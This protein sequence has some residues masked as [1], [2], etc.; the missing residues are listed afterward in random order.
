MTTTSN[1]TARR[2]RQ[3]RKPAPAVPPPRT[4]SQPEIE[5]VRER[6]ALMLCG[7]I[8]PMARIINERY[9]LLEAEWKA[10]LVEAEA[11]YQSETGERMPRTSEEMVV[12]ARLAG[13]T[14]AEAEGGEYNLDQIHRQLIAGKRLDQRQATALV[15][16]VRVADSAALVDKYQRAA[17]A[18]S[19]NGKKIIAFLMAND[20]HRESDAAPRRLIVD[21]KNLRLSEPQV[22]AAIEH[23][24]PRVAAQ[25]GAAIICGKPSRGTWLTPEG[26]EVAKRIDKKIL[27]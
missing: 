20:A 10:A 6:S 7:F 12:A 25:L 15:N 9:R 23:H 19:L 24:I 27:G 21:D 18:L 8:T 11:D 4:L 2:H 5:A 3:R 13:W 26:V 16:A 1:G 14:A 17:D 22:K